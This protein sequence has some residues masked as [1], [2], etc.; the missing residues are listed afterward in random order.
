[1][2]L[3]VHSNQTNKTYSSVRPCILGGFGPII[4]STESMIKIVVE[5]PLIEKVWFCITVRESQN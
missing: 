4:P 3:A 5:S 1:M 2:T